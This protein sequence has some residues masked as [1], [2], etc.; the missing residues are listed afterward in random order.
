MTPQDYENALAA[1]YAANPQAKSDAD[2][3]FFVTA[4]ISG[5]VVIG[6]SVAAL[7]HLLFEWDNNRMLREFRRKHR[8]LAREIAR[9]DR[10][11]RRGR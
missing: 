5:H 9:Q 8:P 6:G 11:L 10:V 4:L 2:M 3:T 7:L 1:Y